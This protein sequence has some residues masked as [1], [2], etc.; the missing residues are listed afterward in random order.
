LAINSM[1]QEQRLRHNETNLSK[2]AEFFDRYFNDTWDY[3][4]FCN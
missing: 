1:I 4:V 3:F 2:Y